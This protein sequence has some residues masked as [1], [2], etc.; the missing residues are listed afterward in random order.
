MLGAITAAQS[1]GYGIVLGALGII[2]AEKL[3]LWKNER[4]IE[5]RPL[6]CALAVAAVSGG[7]IMFLDLAV[8]SNSSQAIADSYAVKPTLDF[9]IASVLYG[10]VIE[11]VMLR[12]F[13]MSLVALVLHKIFD[14]NGEV[15]TSV[16]VAANVVAAIL[17]A[18][19][20][21]PN[22]IILLGSTPLII[23]RC[24]LL[25]GGVGILLGRLYR[26]YGLRYAMIAHAGC[27]VVMKLIWVLAV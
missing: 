12:L 22:T 23:A 2:L 9:I 11:E 18:A 10:G 8:F 3:G 16:L 14:K 13:M 19:G 5:P 6:L 7:V 15:S 1:V 24:F 4:K 20:H 25:N 21:I 17:F 27:H 26:K